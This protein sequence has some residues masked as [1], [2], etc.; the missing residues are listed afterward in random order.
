ML[1]AICTVVQRFIQSLLLC[2][3]K[4]KIYLINKEAEYKSD[5]ILIFYYFIDGY[6]HLSHFCD[7]IKLLIPNKNNFN[8]V[9]YTN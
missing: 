1:C 3:E 4:Y 5:L 7:N 8:N 6:H 2:N 9:L